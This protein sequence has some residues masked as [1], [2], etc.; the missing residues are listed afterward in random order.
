MLLHSLDFSVFWWELAGLEGNTPHHRLSTLLQNTL[1][2]NCVR[3]AEQFCTEF[4]QG[5]LLI[6][7]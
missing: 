3:A 4:T 6:Q 5:K 7:L 1:Y 2:I